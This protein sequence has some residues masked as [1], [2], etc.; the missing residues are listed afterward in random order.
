[1]APN[2]LRALRNLIFQAHHVLATTKLPDSRSER[3]HELLAAAVSLADHLLTQSPAAALGKKGGK[4]TAKRGS[5]YFRKIAAMRKQR[6]GGR[7]PKDP[8]AN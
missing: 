5:E 7:P 1:M 8:G 6:K 2:D 4:Q 3:A